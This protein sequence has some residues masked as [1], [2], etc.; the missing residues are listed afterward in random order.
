MIHIAIGAAIGAVVGGVGAALAARASGKAITGKSNLAGVAGGVAFGAIAAKTC[1]ASLA[2]QMAGFAAAGATGAVVETGTENALEGRPLGQNMGRNAAYGAVGSAIL[3]GVGK[4]V[5]KPLGSL[6]RTPLAKE[7]ARQALVPAKAG[8]AKY[9]ALLKTHPVLTKSTTSGGTYALGDLLAQKLGGNKKIDKKRLALAGAIGFCMYG[10]SH[11]YWYKFMDKLFPKK[12]LMMA[13]A[14]MIPDRL[15]FSTVYTA[16]YFTASGLGGGMTM[17]EVREKLRTDLFPTMVTNWSI[18]PFVQLFNFRFIPESHQVL[19]SST[20]VLFWSAYLAKVS[21]S[22]MDTN[23][24]EIDKLDETFTTC[25]ESDVTSV[26][27][28]PLSTFETP[29]KAPLTVTQPTKSCG[30]IGAIGD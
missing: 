22:G 7:A 19:F 20:A 25:A 4:L 8:W 28:P 29:A 21:N 17:N 1:G 14:K 30:L 5:S 10:P 16:A 2:M 6:A 24:A 12:T 3:P 23:E 26:V 11:H 27:L 9:I 18:T 15:L 13:V